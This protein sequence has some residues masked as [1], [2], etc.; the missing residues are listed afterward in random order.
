MNLLKV[1]F[2][3]VILMAVCS[4]QAEEFITFVKIDGKT[5]IATNKAEFEQLQSLALLID[6]MKTA[7]AHGTIDSTI[8]AEKTASYFKDARRS[9][10][11]IH[12]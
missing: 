10:V 6:A 11:R 12:N 3:V 9:G 5:C 7:K 4:I 8:Y 2:V 1:L